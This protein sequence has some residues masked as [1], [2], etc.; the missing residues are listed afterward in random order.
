V[1]FIVCFLD[2]ASTRRGLSERKTEIGAWI[3]PITQNIGNLAT[4]SSGSGMRALYRVARDR[5]MRV[6]VNVP[7]AAA[8]DIL[9]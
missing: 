3:F 5:P 2:E 7:Q 6:L 9:G 1:I 4:A 8:D